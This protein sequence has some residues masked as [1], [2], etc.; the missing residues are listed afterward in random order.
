MGAA[1]AQDF[2]VGS[3]IGLSSARPQVEGKVGSAAGLRMSAV[4]RPLVRALDT[5]QNLFM[6]RRI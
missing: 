4:F 6:S 3:V 1:H 5:L 2:Q